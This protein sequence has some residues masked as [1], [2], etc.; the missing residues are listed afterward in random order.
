MIALAVDLE[1]WP[2]ALQGIEKKKKKNSFNWLENRI[3][4]IMMGT[5]P[6]LGTA[7]Y[8]GNPLCFII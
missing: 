1:P 8:N 4:K 7:G 3:F 5:A 6:N 2:L